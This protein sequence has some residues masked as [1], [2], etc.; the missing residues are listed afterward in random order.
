MTDREPTTCQ[1]CPWEQQYPDD[2]TAARGLA[3]HRQSL[4][5][6]QPADGVVQLSSVNWRERAI[7]A[8]RL[9]AQRGDDFAFWEIH[10]FGVGDP[11]ANHRTAWGLLAKDVHRLGVAHP[12]DWQRSDRPG[13]KQSGVRKWSGDASRCV[14]C[15]KNTRGASA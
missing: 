13:T 12:V 10:S 3:R 14:D 11:P 8:I 5:G 2:T 6:E 4:H 1:T 7:T 9:L 15:A